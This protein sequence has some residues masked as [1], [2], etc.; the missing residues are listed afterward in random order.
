[1]VLNLHGEVPSDP[2]SNIHVLNAEPR[3]LPHLH[4]LHAAFPRLRIVLEHATTRA[5]VEA[6][7]ACGPTVACTITA[8]HLALTVDDWAGQSWHYAKPVPKYPDDRAALREVVREGRTLNSS[9]FRL[10]CH[11]FISAH[12]T[13]RPPTILLGF[14]F[15][16]APG[17]HES[18]KFAIQGLC[19]RYIHLADSPAPRRASLGVIRCPG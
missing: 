5:A 9:S 11:L 13:L 7:K 6:V 16:S 18:N 14:R 15:G 10:N 19:G 8:H 2:T 1:M 12:D 3:F 4:K 17:T